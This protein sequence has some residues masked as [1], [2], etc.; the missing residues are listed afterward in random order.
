ML[1]T[2]ARPET[3]LLDAVAAE[4]SKAGEALTVAEITKRILANGS[5]SSTGKT[6][7][8]TVEARLAVDVKSKVASSRFVRVAPRMYALAGSAGAVAAPAKTKPV[9]GLAYLDAAEKV[10]EEEPSHQPIGYRTITERA[11]A[12]GYLA[13]SGLTPERTMYVQIMT[14]VKRRA[15]RA[16]EPRF[17]QLPKGRFGLAKWED[18]DLVAQVARH[19][20]EVKRKLL[21]QVREMKWREF[22]LLAG[23]LLTSLGFEEVRVTKPADDGGVDVVGT[24]V[25]GGVIRQRMAVQVKKWAHNVQ[26]PTVQQV[27]GSLGAH[28][29]GLIITTSDFSAGAREEAALTDRAPVAL[30]N[31]EELVALMVEHEIGV[32]RRPLDL[33]ELADL[34]LAPNQAAND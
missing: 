24:L 6:P 30:M 10:L 20:R 23:E 1:T 31:G 2:A 18:S 12:K 19:N 7:A 5:W 11:I 16:D 4:L 22:E 21:A 32:R 25:T 13:S 15:E 34:L 33:L 17:S 14:D 29:E 27:R 26:A 9:G 3:G 28:D 8:A